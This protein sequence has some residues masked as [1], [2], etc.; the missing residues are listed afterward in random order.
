THSLSLGGRGDTVTVPTGQIAWLALTGRQT[1]D[2]WR[3]A[4]CSEAGDFSWA[5]RR[6]CML[7]GESGHMRGHL[8]TQ[9]SASRAQQV[10]PC[11]PVRR[12]LCRSA[13]SFGISFASPINRGGSRAFGEGG[14]AGGSRRDRWASGQACRA[15]WAI[16]EAIPGP[17]RPAWAGDILD[18]ACSRLARVKF[19]PRKART[20]MKQLCFLLVC[21]FLLAAALSAGLASHAKPL[22]PPKHFTND[23]GIKF[24]WVPPGTF[25]MGSPDDE[26]G[27]NKNESQHKVRLTKGFY[28]GVATVTK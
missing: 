23:I 19:A 24:V 6:H 20:A 5:A 21:C 10:T 9:L 28:L 4:W 1:K 16:Y 27:R 25:I 8:P 12:S 7:V 2:N 15:G 11:W 26:K 18:L 3:N 14:D 13:R 22:D 17:L